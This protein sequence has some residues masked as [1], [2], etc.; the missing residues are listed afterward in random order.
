MFSIIFGVL[1]GILVIVALG[2]IFGIAYV[3]FLN[4][5]VMPIF[6][7]IILLWILVSNYKNEN[8]RLSKWF[9]KLYLLAFMIKPMKKIRQSIIYTLIMPVILLAVSALLFSSIAIDTNKYL[10][11]AGI[12]FIITFFIS[13][14][15]YSESQSNKLER[16]LSQFSIWLII[17][18]GFVVLNIYQYTI[19]LN[20]NLKRDQILNLLISILSFA[21]VMTT[22]ADKTRNLYELSCKKY[23]E[24][25]NRIMDILKKEYNY[26]KYVHAIENEKKELLQ[27]IGIM[28]N[29]WRRGNKINVIKTV[30]F[31]TL[32]EVP[33]IFML[34]N[35]KL[36]SDFMG[37]LTNS[38]VKLWISIFRGN[39]ELAGVV[40][41]IILSI[42]ILSI[43]VKDTFRNF[44]VSTCKVK[45][46][47]INKIFLILIIIVTVTSTLFSGSLIIV[48]KYI[49][50]PLIIL[51][52]LGVV[53]QNKVFKV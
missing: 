25:I 46:E 29:K 41:V 49:T 13:L 24:N 27:G 15:L 19:Y 22:I 33:I 34:F 21:F 32:I 37:M 20:S 42:V 7:F 38:S 1:L 12:I 43:T 10:S 48:T 5:M 16:Y 39:K 40:F 17:F 9:L 44:K 47:Y 31:I 18:L 11:A 52:V 30:L 45:M 14:L 36:V 3:T 2:T 4:I 6:I 35:K 26:K 23:D 50:F 53:I 51:F 8:F 28:K